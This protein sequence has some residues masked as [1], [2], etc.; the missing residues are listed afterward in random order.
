MLDAV[1]GP[2][3]TV[4]A[5]KELRVWME[6]RGVSR[7]CGRCTLAGQKRNRNQ[8]GWKAGMGHQ[9]RLSGGDNA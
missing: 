7:N 3:D 6:D 5:I 9:G 1:M 4:L 8:P 2:G